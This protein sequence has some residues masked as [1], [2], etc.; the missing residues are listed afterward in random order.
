[1]RRLIKAIEEKTGSPISPYALDKILRAMATDAYGWRIVDI[2]DQPFPVVA[3]TLK[4]MEIRG[5]LKFKGS[6]VDLTRNGKDLL[7]QRGIYPK[8]DFRCTHCKGTG[9]DISTYADLIERFKEIVQK[10]PR[11]ES[12]LNRWIMTPESAFRR[13]MLMVQKG[14]CPGKNI[15]LLKDADLVGLALVLTRLPNSVT[16]LEDDPDMAGYLKELA[17][18]E[19]F[20][21]SVFEYDLNQPVPE[22]YLGKF[23]VA[24][25]DPPEDYETLLLHLKRSLAFLKPGEGQ[26]AFFGLTHTE[27]SLRKWQ[28]LQRDLLVMNDIVITDILYEFTDY[29]NENF[30]VEKIGSDISIFQEKPTVP[31][32]KSCVY[33]LETLS[34][35]QP[36]NDAIEF[37][38][39]F[40]VDTE[41]LAYS[42]NQDKQDEEKV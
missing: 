38:E 35:F 18:S 10:Y 29:E 33:R 6:R 15:V 3:E 20:P 9:Y 37:R 19:R 4:Q 1:L 25:T 27:A 5:F 8:A 30:Q 2:S 24:V 32:Y 42:K 39:E 36:Q 13:V 31:W 11:P 21:L 26:A 16:V 40:D 22:D 17:H 28:I 23:D 41:Q 12:V 14:N 34:D 7:R